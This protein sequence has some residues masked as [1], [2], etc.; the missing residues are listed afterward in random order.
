MVAVARTAAT[1]VSAGC[2]RNRYLSQAGSPIL[3]GTSTDRIS[4]AIDW[5]KRLL[6]PWTGMRSHSK[7][8]R[9]TYISPSPSQAGATVVPHWNV[10]MSDE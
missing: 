10:L 8:H 3:A 1:M 2:A 6:P 9:G 4:I 7:T 5:I